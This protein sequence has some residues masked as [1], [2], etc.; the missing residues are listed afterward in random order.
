MVL[1][2]QIF[3][4]DQGGDPDLVI[5][6]QRRRGKGPETVQAV[7]DADNKWRKARFDLDR[8]KENKNKLDKEIATKKKAKENADD[9]IVQRDGFDKTVTELEA[10]AEKLAAEVDKVLNPIGNLVHSSVFVSNDE[11][12]NPIVKKW[13]EFKQ[14]PKHH[15]ELLYMIDGYDAPRGVGV[16]GHRAYFLKG[17]GVQLNFAIQT[18]GMDFIRKRTYTLLQPPYFMKK[19]AMAKTAQLEQFD[20]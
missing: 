3:R 6:S 15:H 18:Y 17:V 16:A 2:I 13:G 5:E 20:E 19:D 11:E 12:F 1:D 9:L 14:A 4:K 7:I 10:E 8:A